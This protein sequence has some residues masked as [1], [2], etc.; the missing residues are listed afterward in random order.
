[1]SPVSASLGDNF[2]A[3]EGSSSW[4]ELGASSGIEEALTNQGFTRPSR[5]QVRISQDETCSH[6]PCG[7]Y[8]NWYICPCMRHSIPP[9]MQPLTLMYVVL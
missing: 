8:Q 5:V 9:I 2:F 1:L 3:S 7:V 4:S 6:E